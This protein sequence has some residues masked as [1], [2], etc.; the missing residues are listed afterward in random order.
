MLELRAGE[1]DIDGLGLHVLQGGLRLN[2][3]ELVIDTGLVA[4]PGEFERFLVGF[5]G[6]VQNFLQLVLPAD[7][8]KDLC[9]AG[10]F[11]QA[12]VLQVGRAELR[13]VLKLADRVADLAKEIGRPG[14][15]HGQGVNR[16]LLA[17]E[18]GY[19]GGSAG[20][21]RTG[22]GAR[23]GGAVIRRGGANGRKILR[24]GLTDQ[25][26]GNQEVLVGLLD[27]LV[28]DIELLFQGVEFGI[29]EDL[30]PFAAEHAFVGL[31]HLPPFGLLEM[32]RRLLVGRRRWRR[33]RWMILGAD[34][35]SAERD[36]ERRRRSHKLG[37]RPRFFDRRRLCI[38][39]LRLSSER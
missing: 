19:S 39:S 24:A 35:A 22:K 21:P 5:H 20:R 3:R 4:R 17:G 2:Y 26:T 31:R 6:L 27:V 11:D 37:S 7:L 32:R 33:R 34:G 25:G 16:A 15:V 12:F 36:D 28:I 9:E 30:P 29:L 18:G 10:L 1:T 38:R 8:E 13:A 14:D 23:R